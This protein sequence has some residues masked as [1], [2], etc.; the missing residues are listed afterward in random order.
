MKLYTPQTF[1]DTDVND[2]S[3]SPV[4]SAVPKHLRPGHALWQRSAPALARY[5]ATLTAGQGGGGASGSEMIRKPQKSTA[6]VEG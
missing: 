4:E 2:L 1:T 3:P 6:G 5:T